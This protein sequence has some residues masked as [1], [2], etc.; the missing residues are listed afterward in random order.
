MTEVLSAVEIE[1]LVHEIL[2]PTGFHESYCQNVC[3]G[4]FGSGSDLRILQ[5]FVF[6]LESPVFAALAA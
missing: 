5:G 4:V 6:G 2:D 1:Q 3:S